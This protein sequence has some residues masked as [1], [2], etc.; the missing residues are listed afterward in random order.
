MEIEE[1]YD[2]IYSFIQRRVNDHEAAKDLT[3]EVFIKVI[4]HREDWGDVKHFNGWLYRIARNTLIDHHR[5]QQAHNFNADVRLMQDL[6]ESKQ[7]FMEAML[8][9]Q[10]GF[11]QS[12]VPQEKQLLEEVDIKHTPQKE[13]AERFDMPYSTLKSRVQ[14]ARQKV[15][16]Q[17]LK[18]CAL[19]FDAAG[20]VE[21]CQHITPCGAEKSC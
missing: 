21:S 1:Y 10:K 15:K 3:Q 5:R 2:R 8:E 19:D 7:D 20:R 11:L 6:Q 17:F 9:C 13:L 16:E 18:Q 14:R 12:L 4:E